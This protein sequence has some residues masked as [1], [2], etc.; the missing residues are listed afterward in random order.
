MIFVS[1]RQM[2][3]GLI[4][5]IGYSR[6]VVHAHASYVNRMGSN[7]SCGKRNKGVGGGKHTGWTPWLGLKPRPSHLSI[8]I[9]MGSA[10]PACNSITRWNDHRKIDGKSWHANRL[11][12][13]QGKRIMRRVK[14][15]AFYIPCTKLYSCNWSIT[16]SSGTHLRRPIVSRELYT[17]SGLSVTLRGIHYH[18]LSSLSPTLLQKCLLIC[19]GSC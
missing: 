6:S 18:L 13:R 9:I 3:R 14:D 5:L 2:R 11:R 7:V 4:G 10:L 1:K 12:R 8:Q 17:S 15:R 19:N 16:K